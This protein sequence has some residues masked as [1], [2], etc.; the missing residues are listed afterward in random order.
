MRKRRVKWKKTLAFVRECGAHKKTILFIG[1][2]REISE[3]IQT[4]AEDLNMGYVNV[5]WIGGLLSNFPEISKRFKQMASM[6]EE[7]ESGAWER[8]YVKKEQLRLDNVYQKMRNKF[9][10]VAS[11][12]HTPDVLF[13][14][15]PKKEHIAVTEARK[16]SIPVIGFSNGSSD[17]S[18]LDYIILGNNTAQKSVSFVLDAIK[19]AYI[20]K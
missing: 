1:T 13:V 12:T 2:K 17:L 4:V 8:R 11:F 16:C 15:D 7:K 10:G 20:G 19:N 14:I 3:S 5:R 6:K 18:Q 9:E